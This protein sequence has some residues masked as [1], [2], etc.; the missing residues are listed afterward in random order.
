MLM[1]PSAFPSLFLVCVAIMLSRFSVWGK[2][3]IST[4]SKNRLLVLALRI[5][6]IND[7]GNRINVYSSDIFKC[8]QVDN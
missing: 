8:H 1:G 6:I 4:L 2:Y 3:I 7:T 5:L